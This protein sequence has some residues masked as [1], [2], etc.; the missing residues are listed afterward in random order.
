MLLSLGV[1]HTNELEQGEALSFL[2]Q[3]VLRH[4]SHA[5]AAAQ[6][7]PVDDSSQAAAHVVRRGGRGMGAGG[8]AAW[9]G[10]THG[11]WL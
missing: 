10:S 1:S 3:W 9:G 5:A 8:V 11:G 2:R 7:P 4:P 6:V